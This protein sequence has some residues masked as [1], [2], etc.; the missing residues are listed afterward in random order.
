MTDKPE[1]LIIAE[2][3][4]KEMLEADDTGNFELYTK[5][6]ED[7]YLEGFSKTIFD[8]DIEHMHERNGKN[9]SYELLGTLRNSTVDDLDI[10]RSVWKG[11][12]EKRDAVIEI[13]VYQ[14][15]GTWY[16]IKSAVY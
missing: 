5:R 15:N 3:Y 11:V 16:V 14:K 13:A 2:K 10:F 12:Y 1:E 7:I 6:F 4:L 8:E 9:I